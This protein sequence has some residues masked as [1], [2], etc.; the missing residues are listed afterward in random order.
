MLIQPLD[1]VPRV[2]HL[3]LPIHRF[4]STTGNLSQ[5]IRLKKPVPALACL[6]SSPE[7][8]FFFFFTAPSVILGFPVPG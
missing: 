5:A 8:Y 2:Q 3:T 6:L 4:D 7:V 1:W